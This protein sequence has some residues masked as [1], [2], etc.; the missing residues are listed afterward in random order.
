MADDVGSMSNEI[1]RTPL[2]MEKRGATR[3]DELSFAGWKIIHG[4]VG[5]AIWAKNA[6]PPPL[7]ID[8]QV[9]R[10]STGVWIDGLGGPSI[11]GSAGRF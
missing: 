4:S 7:T 6:D 5:Y 3:Q 1:G 11:G 8:L 2:P 9:R 10:F